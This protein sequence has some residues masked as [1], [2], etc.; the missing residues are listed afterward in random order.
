MLSFFFRSVV[1]I[2]AARLGP[3]DGGAVGHAHTRR[4]RGR[5][6]WLDM[7]V[8]RASVTLVS[9]M[10]ARRGE[11]KKKRETGKKQK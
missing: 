6:G 4:E 9:D 5:H 8:T 10:E 7:A 11:K 2:D 1:L 3:G